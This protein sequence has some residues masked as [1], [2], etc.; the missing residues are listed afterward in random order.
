M[1]CSLK[2][3][4]GSERKRT[5]VKPNA[6]EIM[7]HHLLMN[8]HWR[9]EKL[10]LLLQRYTNAQVLNGIGDD[11][12]QEQQIGEAWNPFTSLMIAAFIN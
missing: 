5:P 6:S 2:L 1:I 10:T 12:L 8:K 11:L 7:H 9:A 3:G 4:I